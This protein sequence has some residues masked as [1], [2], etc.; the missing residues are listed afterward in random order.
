MSNKEKRNGGK[1]ENWI[2]I[3][4]S[5]ED[6]VIVGTVYGDTYWRDGDSLRTSLIVEIRENEAETLNTIYQLGEKGSK[7]EEDLAYL[8]RHYQKLFG[9]VQ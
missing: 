5:E 2:Q 3:H 8:T 6:S 1:I 9:Y 4:L 7:S